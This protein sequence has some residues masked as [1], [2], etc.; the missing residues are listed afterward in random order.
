[1]SNVMFLLFARHQVEEFVAA[2]PQED[3]W[4]VYNFCT[5]S[6][7]E[8][9][10]E[11]LADFLREKHP[12]T[13]KRS[14]MAT[15]P[16]I[17][18]VRRIAQ[19]NP[20][21]DLGSDTTIRNGLDTEGWFGS[22]EVDWNDSPVHVQ[23]IFMEQCLAKEPLVLIATKSNAALRS[24]LK[25]LKQYGDSRQAE[26]QE[27]LVVNGINLP[28][29][30]TSWDEVVLPGTLADDIQR[31]VDG[32]FHSADKYRENGL[33]Y[34]RGFLFAGP[35]GCGKTFTIGA[36]ANAVKATTMAIIR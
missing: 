26:K 35:P 20:I 6:S 3:G 25:A 9:Y 1:M 17:E 32:F 30:K 13:V 14:S 7:R 8:L 28:K 18:T 36:L 33:P 21:I 22:V 10:L 5:E 24:L 16:S 29:P 27:I 34:R 23:S 15:E 31:N 11:G 12:G 2:H 19:S 4:T